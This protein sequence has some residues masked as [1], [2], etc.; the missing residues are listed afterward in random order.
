VRDTGSHES[1]WRGEAART[2]TVP[3]T[4]YRNN[5]RDED[6]LMN[7][8]TPFRLMLVAPLAVMGLAC[9][10]DSDSSDSSDARPAASAA[11][12][13]LFV[14]LLGEEGLS[15]SDARAAIDAACVEA[16]VSSLSQADAEAIV[17]NIDDPQVSAEGEES[18]E[19]IAD[20]VS[21]DG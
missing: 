5:P 8:R 18:L 9:G 15:D 16:A 14:S 10:N 21:F 2:V 17:A 12:I 3:S 11:I 13:D 6:T 1:G 7:L 20:C 19:V 4:K